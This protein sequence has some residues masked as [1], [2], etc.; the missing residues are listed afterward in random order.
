MNVSSRQ[1]TFSARKAVRRQVLGAIVFAAIVSI[2]SATSFAITYNVNR[3]IGAGGVTGFIKTDGTLGA[4][5]PVNVTDWNLLL[6]DGSGT[7]NLLGPLSG[8]NSQLGI[9]GLSYVATP[10][11]ILFDFSNVTGAWVLYQNP[12]LGSSLNYYC[13]D[14]TFNGCS[15]ATNAET[16]AL[17][18]PNHQI[19]PHIGIVSVAS[20]IPEPSALALLGLGLA[21]IGLGRRRI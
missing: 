18:F 15:G 8:N 2:S 4:L 9:N 21:V 20:V 14:G 3:T 5:T 7:F 11:D 1:R 6:D 16:V 13:S 10:T 17:V 19:A 12:N